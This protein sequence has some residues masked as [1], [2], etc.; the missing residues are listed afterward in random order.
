MAPTVQVLSGMPKFDEDTP[1]QEG[2]AVGAAGPSSGTGAPG[3]ALSLPH[4][5]THKHS[6][7]HTLSL[8]HTLSLS[9]FLTLSLSHSITLTLSQKVSFLLFNSPLLSLSTTPRTPGDP[10]QPLKSPVKRPLSEGKP[11]HN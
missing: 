2:V 7:P 3:T 6:R 8:T 10:E 9:H 11:S 1:G 4:S 5:H